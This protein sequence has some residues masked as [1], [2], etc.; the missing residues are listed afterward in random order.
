MSNRKNFYFRQKVAENELDAAFAYAEDADRAQN[1]DLGFIGVASGAVVSPQGSPNLTVQVASGAAYDKLGRRCLIPTSQTV[2]A[3]QDFNAVTTAVT[4]PGNAKWISIFLLF[5][6]TLTD[7]RVDGNSLTVYFDEAEGFAFKVVQSV[8]A[9]VPTRPSLDAE[10]L[11]LCDVYRAF[12][13]TTI[14][15]PNIDTTR[16]EAAF[17]VSGTPR[18]INRGKVT[19]AIGDLLGWLNNHFTGAADR[20]AA[21]AVDYAGGTT[22]ADATTNPATTVELQIDKIIADLRSSTSSN[23]GAH[24]IGADAQ[25]SGSFSL[26]AGTLRSQLGA[27]LGFFNTLDA[28]VVKLAG[29]QTV[30]GAKTFSNLITANGASGDANP[31][32][33]S[34]PFAVTAFKLLWRFGVAAGIRWRIYV[35]SAGNLVI[36]CNAAFSSGTTWAK[37]VSGAI[38]WIATVEQSQITLERYDATGATVDTASTRVGRAR[39]EIP[40][41]TTGSPADLYLRR[42]AYLEGPGA[43]AVYGATGGYASGLATDYRFSIGFP[44]KFPA[45]PSSVTLGGVSSVNIATAA[46]GNQQPSG[47]RI[48]LNVSATGD[49]AYAT[50]ATVS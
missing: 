45:S 23:S 47:I 6:R 3:A 35:S 21:A 38:A 41:G 20:H 12:G 10:G 29:T 27:L 17:T 37:D 36:S 33:E 14:T 50:T 49:Y 42:E 39:V 9:P 11:L 13:Q 31:A 8:E 2:N 32:I 43:I 48:D 34:G 19:E 7:P 4:N 18:A 46:V 28:A 24:K 44:K 25:T 26:S 40:I 22:W 15:A 1:V 30:T 5:D 16:R